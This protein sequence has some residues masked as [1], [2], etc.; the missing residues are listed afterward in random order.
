MKQKTSRPELM[1]IE[2]AAIEINA[3]TEEPETTSAV[4][5]ALIR[6][7]ADP[8]IRSLFYEAIQTEEALRENSAKTYK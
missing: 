7:L 2:T 8:K 4:K 3:K 6:L 5:K 1:E